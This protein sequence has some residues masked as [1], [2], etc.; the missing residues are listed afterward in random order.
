MLRVAINAPLSKLFDYLPPEGVLPAPGCRVHVPFGR[1]KQV[2]LVMEIAE[3][4]EVPDAKLKKV[5]AVLDDSPLLDEVD[6]WL[7]SFTSDYYHHPVGEVV[8]AALPAAGQTP[9]VSCQ[10]SFCDR[11]RENRRPG[12]IQEASAAPGC[13]A[14]DR[15]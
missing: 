10:E 13:L 9:G 15:S 8:A 3:D 7:I 1:Q 4:S 12:D 2:G 5:I 14:R 11:S 6:R